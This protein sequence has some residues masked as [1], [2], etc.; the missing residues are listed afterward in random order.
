[1]KKF[2]GLLDLGNINSIQK[3][4]IVK[5]V[6]NQGKNRMIRMMIIIILRQ[7][8]LMFIARA[9]SSVFQKEDLKKMA[10]IVNIYFLKK[11]FF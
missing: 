3:E 10:V 11:F 9:R 2:R 4:I 6:I 8:V 1:M 7:K 5:A